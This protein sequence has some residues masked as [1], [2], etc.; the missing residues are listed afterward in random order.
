M[1]TRALSRI[2]EDDQIVRPKIRYGDCGSAQGRR[3]ATSVITNANEEW[4]DFVKISTNGRC[5]RAVALKHERA[6]CD[7]AWVHWAESRA[8]IVGRPQSARV[9]SVRPRE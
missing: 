4:P 7:R 8:P 6:A 1:E 5:R 2:L 9:S 3:M